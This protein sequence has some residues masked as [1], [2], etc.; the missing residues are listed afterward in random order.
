MSPSMAVDWLK[1]N[2]GRFIFLWVILFKGDG[3][4]ADVG[5]LELA[6][7]DDPLDTLVCVG[8]GFFDGVVQLFDGSVK[9]WG[10]S[11]FLDGHN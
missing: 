8:V 4:L 10:V 1:S 11:N 3:L 7:W 2:C 5:P 9:Y 6:R